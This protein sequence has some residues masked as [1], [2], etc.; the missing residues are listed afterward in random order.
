M[1]R[2][3]YLDAQTI[4]KIGERA[5]FMLFQTVLSLRITY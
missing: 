2:Y 4:P 1:Q 5:H 3:G